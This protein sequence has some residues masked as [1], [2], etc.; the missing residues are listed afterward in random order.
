MREQYRAFPRSLVIVVSLLAAS[1]AVGFAQPNAEKKASPREA[2][3]AAE[4]PSQQAGV[5]VAAVLSGSPAD[6]AGIVR[7]DII[8]EAGGKAVNAP[9]EL[10]AAVEVKKPGDSLAMKVRHGSDV[11]GLTV[12]LAD[13]DG[14]PWIGIAPSPNPDD[15]IQAPW[16]GRGGDPRIT[17]RVV[18]FDRMQGVAQGANVMSVAKDGP[19]D[20]AGIAAGDLILAVDG[21]SVEAG[22]SLGDLIAAHKAGD[23][24]TL[25]VRSPGKEARDVQVTLGKKP[26]ADAPLL[27]VEYTSARARGP[28]FALPDGGFGAMAGV[29]VAQVAPD[30]PAAKA[31]V[32][33]RDLITAVEGV[34]V[35]SPRSVAEAV[36][37]HKPGDSLTVTVARMPDGKSTDLTVTLG[38]N[39]SDKTKGYLG[40]SMS[41]FIGLQGPA[42]PDSDSGATPMMPWPGMPRFGAP[43][44]TPPGI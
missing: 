22:G 40:I 6:R 15:V 9:E 31:G 41:S 5:L 18:P 10:R 2:P 16:A 11:R 29:L 3:A 7:G 26:D 32:K 1:A 33:E 38:E 39:P 30:G 12:T 24:V 14:R 8:L 13:Q 25:S 42:R 20:K 21:K 44:P 4:Q 28:G 34:R 37:A 17:P 23:L 36:A 35:R 27:G 43:A 19:A